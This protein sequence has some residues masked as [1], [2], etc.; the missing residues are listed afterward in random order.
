MPAA[1][2]AWN[3]VAR[4]LGAGAA[5][6]LSALAPAADLTPLAIGGHLLRDADL[7]S[8]RFSD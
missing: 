5:L 7:F 3:R 1:S 8:F 6:A 2:W 4:S